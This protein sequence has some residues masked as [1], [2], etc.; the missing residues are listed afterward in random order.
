MTGSPRL[1]EAL[2]DLG[3]EDLIPLWE[4]ASSDEVRA[5]FGTVQVEQL[6][7]VLVELLHE[8]R[9]QV[10]RGPWPQDPEVVDL[11]TAERL[12]R[13]EQQY[14]P[15]STADRTAR[16]YYAN[17]DNIRGAEAQP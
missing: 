10:W 16:V 12:L 2:L 9:I 3:L 15:N 4:I 13:V 7:A 8:G 5:T 6:A 11:A 1:R 17:V 14:Q